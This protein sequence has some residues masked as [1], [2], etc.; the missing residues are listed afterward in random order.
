[1]KSTHKNGSTFFHGSLI[2]ILKELAKEAKF[3]YTLYEVPDNQYG[4]LSNGSWS[5]L[6]GE[7]FYQVRCNVL[8]SDIY[9]LYVFAL[10][11][12]GQIGRTR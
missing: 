8:L 5:G 1:M 7:V 2:D 9:S 6:I 12:H 10:I 3:T 11:G 4:D